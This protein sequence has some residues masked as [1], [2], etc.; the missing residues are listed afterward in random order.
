MKDTSLE[1]LIVGGVS[2]AT[3]DKGEL[4]PAAA[5]DTEFPLALEADKEWLKW[6]PPIPI[7][8]PEAGSEPRPKSGILNE[9]I[10]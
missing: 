2:F 8:S 7:K 9:L 1:S 10:K 3:P 6:A 4:A 5:A